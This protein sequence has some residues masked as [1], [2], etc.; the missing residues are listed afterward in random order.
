MPVCKH[1]VELLVLQASDAEGEVTSEQAA[2]PSTSEAKTAATARRMRRVMAFPL[3]LVEVQTFSGMDQR[4]GA[5]TRPDRP[6]LRH[7]MSFLGHS[8]WF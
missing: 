1:D 8:C 3:R 7:H 6:F 4:S 5:K 2:V